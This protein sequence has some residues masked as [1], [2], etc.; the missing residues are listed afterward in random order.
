MLDEGEMASLGAS[1]DTES[2]IVVAGD[3]YVSS[4]DALRI[5][6]VKP[7]TLYSYVSRG[8]IRRRVK[9][10]HRSSY[11]NRE[12]IHR[13]KSRSVARSG[14][15]PAAASAMYWGE[16]VL[17]TAITEI[18]P[19]GPRYREDL[20]TDLVRDNRS[21]ES[22]AE[23]L[24]SGTWPSAEQTWTDIAVPASLA[25]ELGKIDPSDFRYVLTQSIVL[26]AKTWSCDPALRDVPCPATSI[27]GV[28]TGAFGFLGPKREFTSLENGETVAHALTRALGIKPSANNV[29]ALNAVLVLTADHELT[30]PTF[31]ARISASAGCDL[32]S[33]ILAGLQV[34]FGYEFGLCCDRLETLLDWNPK[35]AKSGKGG[36][37]PSAPTRTT[38]GFDTPLYVHGDP[39]ANLLL[40]IA[41]ALEERHDHASE[42]LQVITKHFPSVQT[43]V[44]LCEALVVLSQALG[45]PYQAAG[46]LLALARSAGC[47]AH[48]LEQRT[49][50]SIIRPRGKFI[51]APANSPD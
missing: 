8:L 16:P 36:A 25:S 22:V 1:Q 49:Q 45:L 48:V 37:R 11:Y 29:R 13:L 19:D 40:D 41:L 6:Q 10:G 24:W 17:E 2:S 32:P 15:G 30:T 46:G 20:A 43:R 14:H 39:R 7:Q 33:C 26:L 18:T 4:R 21:F 34:H 3:D 50:N 9:P 51:G 12:D 23:Y 27:L 31:V 44:N 28:M 5:L 47:I 35:A 38:P 42:A